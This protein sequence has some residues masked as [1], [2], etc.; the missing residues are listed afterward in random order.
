MPNWFKFTYHPYP[1]KDLKT[2]EIVEVFRPTV[3]IV[4]SSKGIPSWEIQALVDSGSDRNLFPAKLGELIGIDIKSGDKR[5]IQGIGNSNID[6]YTHK[7]KIHIA[8]YSFETEADFS[9]E[10]QSLLLGR[11]GFFNFFKKIE[12]KEKEKYV[13]SIG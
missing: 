13:E 11:D 3:P 2:G 7:I 12:F 4:V 1:G 5:P 10:Q 9:Y 6:A 8:G